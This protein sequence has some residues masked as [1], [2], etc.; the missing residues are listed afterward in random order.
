[1]SY[2]RE[3]CGVFLT[4]NI[5]SPENY[6]PVTAWMFNVFWILIIATGGKQQLTNPHLT[7]PSPHLKSPA[8]TNV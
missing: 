3:I 1:M 8:K 4:E 6:W 5:G 2:T 7:L